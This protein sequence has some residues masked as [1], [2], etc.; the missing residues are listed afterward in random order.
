VRVT[1]IATT[2]PVVGRILEGFF[3]ALISAIAAVTAYLPARALGQ[4]E[5]FWGAIIAIIVAQA[6][7]DASR[8]MAWNQFVA[9]L[10]GCLV[11]MVVVATLGRSVPAYMLGIMLSGL[12]CWAINFSNAARTSAV[13]VTLIVLVP[14][15]GTPA[16]LFFYR[17]SEVTWGALV[18]TAVAWVMLQVKALLQG[19]GAKADTGGAAHPGA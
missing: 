11:G 8:G 19:S 6:Q 4:R 17:V 10:I 13:S 18:G 9:A 16:H 1:E 2:H 15:L 12:L 14:R 7:L 3:S 5:A